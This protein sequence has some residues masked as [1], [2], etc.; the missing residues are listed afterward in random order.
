MH[1]GGAP[2][3]LMLPA[4]GIARVSVVIPL[5]DQRRLIDRAI[6]SVLSQTMAEFE[7]LVV[8]DGSTDG[9][10]EFV[11]GIRDVRVRCIRCPHRGPGAAR[12]AGVAAAAGE[13]IGLLDADDEWLPRFLEKTTAV[14]G[15]A[16]ASVAVYTGAVGRGG[17]DFR[18][19]MASGVVTDYYAARM[20]H[21]VALTCSSVLL[22]RASLLAAGGFAEGIR[23]AEDVDTWFRLSCEGPFYFV[24]DPL[25]RI[26]IGRD[27]HSTT[28]IGARERAAG[29]ARMLATYE[30]Y[31]LVGR[32]DEIRFPHAR[33]FMQHQRGRMAVHLATAG[34]RFAA[35]R[36]LIS[37]VPL[38]VHTWREYLLCLKRSLLPSRLH[39]DGH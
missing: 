31:R 1:S 37:G 8:D 13:W 15:T 6:A 36:T 11:E 23:Y 10:A 3:E 18:C 38:G 24:A 22:R 17:A 19:R 39:R 34:E 16:P 35:W 33:R 9:G 29:L 30:Q 32:F 2:R 5:F 4:T 21:R 27:R 12:N 28:A 14:V 7:L 26:E 20:R 25:A